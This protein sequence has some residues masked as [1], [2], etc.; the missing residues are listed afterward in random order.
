MELRS[1]PVQNRGKQFRL[2]FPKMSWFSSDVARLVASKQERGSQD[3]VAVLRHGL[4]GG[5]SMLVAPKPE[6]Q[7]GDLFQCFY[8]FT[9]LSA[10]NSRVPSATAVPTP[11]GL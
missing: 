1:I 11:V 9:S 10:E 3:F 2:P 7:V 4:Q 8:T 6:T 5:I